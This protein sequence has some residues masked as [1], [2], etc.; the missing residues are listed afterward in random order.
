MMPASGMDEF[1]TRRFLGTMKAIV[2]LLNESD[3]NQKWIDWF[4]GD[5]DDFNAAKDHTGRA[6]RQMAVVEHVMSAFGGM[7]DFKQ[8]ELSSPESTEKLQNLSTQL[9]SAARGLQGMLLA[10]LQE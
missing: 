10:E 5:L 7:S 9:W 6:A 8:I 1:N 3:D 4:Q 2:Q